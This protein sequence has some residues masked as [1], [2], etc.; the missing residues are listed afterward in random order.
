MCEC[1]RCRGPHAACSPS[2]AAAAAAAAAVV[3]V[4]VGAG[5]GGGGEPA[6]AS[7]PHRLSSRLMLEESRLSLSA[8]AAS[9]ASAGCDERSDSG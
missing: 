2:A 4:V 7:L 8:G 6:T 3:V 1:D 9:D 5:G